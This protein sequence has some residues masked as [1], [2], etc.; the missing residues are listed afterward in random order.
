MFLSRNIPALFK[1]GTLKLVPSDEGGRRR[2]AEAT[3]VIEPFPA[4]L[5]HELGE[6]I[7]GHLFDETGGIRPELD[8][9]DLRVQSGL[10]HLT[11]RHHEEL[12]AIAELSP[13]SI[14]D[15]RVERI[16][17]LKVNRSWLSCS[18]V[19]VFS[20]EEKAARN[21]VLDEF[22][23]TLLWSFDAMQGELLSQ[24][25]LHEAIAR[26]GDPSGDGSTSASFGESGGEMHT[27]DPKKHR[28]EAK[29]LR[30]LANKTH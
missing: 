27:I 26:V 7:A 15:L 4:A 28:A 5:A 3:C 22:G 24:A 16:E 25:R 30:N 13:V 9:I 2:V 29:R 6:E 11:V 12:D 14:K 1:K 8:A 17:D 21:F 18:F 19:L 23:K 10:Q 20:L